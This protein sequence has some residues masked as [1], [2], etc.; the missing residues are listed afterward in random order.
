MQNTLKGTVHTEL[1]A[2]QL[3]NKGEEVSHS[4]AFI[5]S[6]EVA[7]W[8]ILCVFHKGGG[9]WVWGGCVCANSGFGE[10]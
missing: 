9:L 6:C 4:S 8:L 10:V 5:H 1:V 2:I 7:Q 3:H